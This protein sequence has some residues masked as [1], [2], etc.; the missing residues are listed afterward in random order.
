MTKSR[1]QE[2]FKI[3]HITVVVTDCPSQGSTYGLYA[4]DDDLPERR[5]R[6]FSGH[7]E[8]GMTSGLHRLAAHISTL[9]SRKGRT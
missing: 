3:A 4:G 1:T 9:E 6:L 2:T 7:V 5:T 8:D